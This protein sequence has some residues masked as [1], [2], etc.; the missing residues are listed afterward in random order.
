MEHRWAV[1]GIEEEIARV[2]ED[3][4]RIITVP[5]YLLPPGAT[6]GQ[7]LKVTRSEESGGSVQITVAIDE[8]KTREALAKSNA[9]VAKAAAASK[10]RDPGGNLAL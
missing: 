7:L 10:K 6:E 2:E 9:R 8:A 1:D 4:E 3:G 5:R